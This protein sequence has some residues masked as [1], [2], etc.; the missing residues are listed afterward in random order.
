MGRMMAGPLWDP[1]AAARERT[2]RMNQKNAVNY[3]QKWHAMAAVG[4]GVFLS[5]LDGSI[6]NVALPTLVRQLNTEFSVVQWVVLAYLVTAT[7]LIPSMG[8]AAD[9]VGKKA[10]Y[11]A[12]F[13]VFTI[14]SALCGLA[15]TVY[16]LIA[17]R[18][19]QAIGASTM[20][21]LGAAVLTEAFPDSERGKALGFAGVI[22]SLS[23]VVGPALGGVIIA[24]LS[25]RWI[26]LLNLPVGILGTVMVARYITDIRPGRRQP[27]DYAGAIM[28]FLSL[29]ALLLGL[30]FGQQQDFTQPIVHYLIGLA[31]LLITLFVI[32]ENNTS[33]PMIAPA[34]FRDFRFSLHLATGF[35]SFVGLAGV[36]LLMP[37]Y[38]ENILGMDTLHTGLLLGVVPV[39]LG[40]AAPISGM[41]SDRSAKRPIEVIGLAT[42]LAG[43]LAAATLTQH[44]SVP[45]YLLRLF[46]LGVGL[47][48]FITPN[49]SAIMGMAE[50][51]QLGVVSALMAI[52][53]TL[54]QVLGVAVMGAIWAGR[55]AH[56]AGSRI[57]GGATQA[58]VEAQVA[59]LHDTFYAAALM[60]AVALV[61]GIRA[62]LH[63][64]REPQSAWRP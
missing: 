61:L 23:I 31:I 54:G 63:E 30:T 62:Y 27:F 37:F 13:I 53:R 51:H 41:L 33:H 57:P 25:W 18:V 58:P 36:V 26:F 64:S 40:I 11:L 28:L 19:L 35:I 42:M 4:T 12:G 15:L 16:Q 1:T 10:L 2:H 5:T 46:A 9:I 59:A 48:I 44:T 55:T 17:F 34:L 14:G 32:I 49:N 50:D 3:A 22:V 21:A 52:T 39:L 60:L 45:G 29:L 43:Y 20:M 47:G 24:G 7:T 8:R 38:L 56:Y 6:V